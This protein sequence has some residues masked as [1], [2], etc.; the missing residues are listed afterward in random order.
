MFGGGDGRQYGRVELERGQHVLLVP[1]VHAAVPPRFG[2]LQRFEIVPQT[3]FPGPGHRDQT[4]VAEL[5]A[6]V[7]RSRFPFDHHRH[8]ELLQEQLH[9]FPGRCRRADVQ[10]Q[11]GRVR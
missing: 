3:P 9:H 7:N 11:A 1:D 6:R 4:E 10:F 5:G 2:Q 8:V